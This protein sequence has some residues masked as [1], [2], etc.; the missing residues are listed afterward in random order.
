MTTMESMSTKT[1]WGTG[2]AVDR[3]HLLLPDPAPRE[4]KH[5]IISVDD[6]L[7]EPPEVFTGRVPA[8]YRDR[9]PRVVEEDDGREYWLI[10]DWTARYPDRIIGSRL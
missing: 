4:R 2:G 8:R 6:H 1:G 5:V 7:V 9:A 10:E 3:A